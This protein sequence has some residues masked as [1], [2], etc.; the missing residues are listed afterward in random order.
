MVTTEIKQQ[1]RIVNNALAE[2]LR[3]RCDLDAQAEVGVG[4]RYPDVLVN[5]PNGPVILETEFAPA[6]SV[7]DDALAKLG[8]NIRGRSTDITFA[9]VLPQEFK[10]F[11]QRH[12]RDRL[13]VADLEWTTWF[14]DASYEETKNGDFVALSQ[15]VVRTT[16]KGDNLSA[17]VETLEKGAVEAGSLLYSARDR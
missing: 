6:Y 7:H 13:A 10:T 5:L 4:G 1:E 11:H 9:V 12:L 14:S 17:A 15:D 8:L 2:L 16:P 3:D